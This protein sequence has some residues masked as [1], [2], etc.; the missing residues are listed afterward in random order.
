[1]AVTVNVHEAKTRREVG[2]AL[3]GA[4]SRPESLSAT[5]LDAVLDIENDL[6]VSAASA[7]EIATKVRLGRGPG[8][9]QLEAGFAGAIKHVRGTELGIGLE[10]GLLDGRIDWAHRDPFDRILVAQALARGLTII[11]ADA[12]LRSERVPTLW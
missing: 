1:M 2:L 5:A 6:F 12:V 3:A 11:T 7:W 10:D 9:A 8:A 4:L